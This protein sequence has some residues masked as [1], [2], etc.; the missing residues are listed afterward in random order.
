MVS[1]QCHMGSCLNPFPNKPCFL[2]VCSASLLK[3][4]WEKEKLLETSNFSFYQCF[5]LFWRNC[6]K[7][8][9]SPFPT[10]FSTLLELPLLEVWIA[11]WRV[12][13]FKYISCVITEILQN[14]RPKNPL[15]KDRENKGLYDKGLNSPDCTTT[16]S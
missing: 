13:T 16:R 5:L 9:I 8:P 1:Y 10:V 2:R 11:H 7:Q 14:S 4:L 12:N 3:T 6:S 15:S